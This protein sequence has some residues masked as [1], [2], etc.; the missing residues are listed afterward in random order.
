[1]IEPIG[2]IRT[3]FP[4]KFGIPRQSGVVP[5]LEGQ[6]ILDKKYR[7][8]E[9]FRG[10]EDYEYLWLLWQFD[11]PEKED[12]TPTVRPPRLGGNTRMGVFATR[13]PFRP[14]AIG[15][16]CVKMQQLEET[17]EGPIL[18]VSGVD[19]RDRTKI[20]DIKP[21]LPYADA[22]PDAR[23]GFAGQVVYAQQEV[24]A[25]KEV[26]EGIPKDDAAVIIQ[27]LEQDPRPHYQQDETR[28][29]GMDYDRYDVKFKAEDGKIRLLSIKER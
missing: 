23:T 20:L 24:V 25:D 14:N 18:H 4:E 6:I 12:F 11:I 8:M 10:V 26:L 17:D 21:Y 19:L 27:L 2:E 16:S 15:L 7:V 1:M 9:A 28:I 13:S 5:E 29:Y 22:H 3:P